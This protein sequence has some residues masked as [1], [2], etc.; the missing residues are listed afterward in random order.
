MAKK[1]GKSKAQ[2]T[3]L[4]SA[5]KRYIRAHGSK[6]LQDNNVTSVG[7]GR[8]N[9]DGEIS[10]VF[11]VADKQPASELESLGTQLLPETIEI[12]GFRVSTDVLQRD[13]KPS[14]TVIETEGVSDDRKSRLDPFY[15]GASV[16]HYLGSAGTVGAVV[17][18]SDTGAPCILSNWHVLHGN[19]GSV[20]DK[21]VQPGPHDDNDVASNGCGELLRSHLGAAGDCAIARIRGRE[22]EQEIYKLGVVP[23]QIAQVDLDDRVVKSGRTTDVTHGLVRRIDVM[24]KL[25]YGGATG[26]L[27][28]GCFEIGVDP[29]RLP[30]DGEVSR[31]GDSGSAWMISKDGNPTSIFAG[32]H[33]A[34]ESSSNLDEHALACYPKSVRNKL[35]FDLKPPA[36]LLE[37]DDN[38]LSIPRSGFDPNFL[39]ILAPLPDMSLSI[40][41]DA[42]NFGRK[43]LIPYTHFSVCLSARRRMARFVAWNIDGAQKVVLGDH[44]FRIDRRIDPQH[45]LDN[46][47]YSD[48]KLDRGHVAR[49]A[50]LAWGP[51]DE[52][53]QANR[54]SFFYT[55][56]VP[57][58]ERFNRSNK[59]GLWGKLENLILEKAATQDIKVSVI[60]GPIF[61]DRDPEYRGALIPREFWKLIAYK[62]AAGEL[63]CAC[64][65]L[66]QND[67]LQD[68]ETIDFDPFRLFQVSAV[69]L[70]EKTGLG[71]HEYHNIDAFIAPENPETV[72]AEDQLDGGTIE[73]ELTNESDLV[74]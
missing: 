2:Q 8:K 56:I 58:H 27:S 74:L 70:T 29:D 49:R 61:G 40:K 66:S 12:D 54:D 4:K 7:I 34:G 39:G 23:E 13:F 10:L 63:R 5:M 16:S 3:K 57:Q 14:Y 46:S 48:N 35:R 50:D 44:S 47:L 18:D 68:I 65:V 6:F 31:G 59:S 24:V 53:K 25:N 37:D 73:R 33:F 38:T 28:I 52:A 21:V 62:S 32:L 55:N 67:L 15:P 1:A 19:S 30:A 64:F 69:T 43:Q 41:R 17:F 51:V 42:V 22:F 45:Q 72:V 36:T 11:T 20:G 71:F 60:A 9:G 26:V